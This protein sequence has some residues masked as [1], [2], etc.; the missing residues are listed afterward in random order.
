MAVFTPTDWD[1]GEQIRVGGLCGQVDM[2]ILV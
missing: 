2:E 1:F